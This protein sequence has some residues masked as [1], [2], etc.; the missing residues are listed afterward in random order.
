[1]NTIYFKIENK[2]CEETGYVVTK[3]HEV[4]KL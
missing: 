4:G 1:M 2:N 3:I